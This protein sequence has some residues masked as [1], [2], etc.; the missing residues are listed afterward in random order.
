M[1]SIP[2]AVCPQCTKPTPE[3]ASLCVC[4]DI[5]PQEVRRQ[6]LII[7]HPQESREPLST[8]PLIP[9]IFRKAQVRV[10]LSTPNLA[11]ALGREADPKRW[12]VLYLG[13]GKLK[14]EPRKPGL[15]TVTRSK[16]LV[17][18]DPAQAPL[19]GILVLDGSWAQSKALWWRNP[20][21]LKLRRLVLVPES[22]A[23]YHAV[24]REPSR[25]AVS[26][27]EALTHALVMLGETIDVDATLLPVRSLAEKVSAKKPKA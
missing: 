18:Y 10:A 27:L 7:Q 6:I 24:R 1:S 22:R 23:I 25:T 21:L 14:S 13:T 11:R 20:W 26:S 12:G 8:T 2:A 9:M 19:E 17:P 3:G 5:R 4:A 15:Y 16:D